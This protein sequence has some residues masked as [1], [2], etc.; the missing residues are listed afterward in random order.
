MATAAGAPLD[1]V[2]AILY[3]PAAGLVVFLITG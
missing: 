2:L 3:S 1:N